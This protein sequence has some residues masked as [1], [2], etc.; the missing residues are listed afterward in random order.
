MKK[1]IY[2]VTLFILFMFSS[3][4]YSKTIIFETNFNSDAAWNITQPNA[5]GPNEIRNIPTAYTYGATD[6]PSTRTSV[7]VIPRWIGWYDYRTFMTTNTYNTVTLGTSNARGGSGNA[8]THYSEVPAVDSSGDASSGTLYLFLG[9][10]LTSKGYTDIW[11]TVWRKF[12]TNYYE[13][14]NTQ[15]WL[16]VSHYNH[17]LYLS[18]NARHLTDWSGVTTGGVEQHTPKFIHGTQ[19]SDDVDSGGLPMRWHYAWVRQFPYANRT[20]WVPVV[21]DLDAG[22]WKAGVAGEADVYATLDSGT[23]NGG[24][25]TSG[26]Y[27]DGDYHCHE[28]HLKLNSA[29][30]VAD[31]VLEYYIDGVAQ[32]S[33]NNMQWVKSGTPSDLGWN[34]IGFGGNNSYYRPAGELET[35]Y[36]YDDIVVSDYRVTS[37][38]RVGYPYDN[39]TYIKD[40]PAWG[41]TPTYQV[42]ATP[43]PLPSRGVAYRDGKFDTVLYRLTDYSD[44][45]SATILRYT[46]WSPENCDE[47]RALVVGGGSSGGYSFVVVDVNKNSPT[48]AKPL[49]TFALAYSYLGAEILCEPRWHPTDPNKFYWLYG[50][51]LY[52]VDITDAAPDSAKTLV[53]DF[54]SDFP[55]MVSIGTADEGDSS[56]NGR[57]WTWLVYDS[58]TYQYVFVYDSVSNTIISQIDRAEL[59]SRHGSINNV[60]SSDDGSYVYIGGSC[61]PYSSCEDYP[62]HSAA[63]YNL[64][65]MGSDFSKTGVTYLNIWA[66]HQ[67]TAKDSVGNNVAAGFDIGGDGYGY[68][69]V[70]VSATRLMYRPWPIENGTQDVSYGYFSAPFSS[71]VNGWSL[72]SHYPCSSANRTKS[73]RWSACLVGMLNLKSIGYNN[74][75]HTPTPLFYH[76]FHTYSGAYG[77]SGVG[78]VTANRSGSRVYFFTSWNATGDTA[79]GSARNVWMAELPE[80]WWQSSQ[81]GGTTPPSATGCTMSGTSFR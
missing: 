19:R 80:N 77:D 20:D 28:Y 50:M 79:G 59:V 32:F 26:N 13:G 2:L 62:S 69:G 24:W 7:G 5:G 15:K 3:L 61:D 73:N 43:P 72:V 65:T 64:S 41:T 34:S 68:V 67:D 42:D 55:G 63:F 45:S 66:T 53:R 52:L 23:R 29:S 70:G 14:N 57:Y 56:A 35:W 16:S 4:G 51:K 71:S 40:V 44:Y 18:D 9:D 22:D 38:Y 60:M 78:E 33:F 81:L 76:L 46:H 10:A 31:G 58:S 47:T 75:T 54:S 74:T 8:I 1:M 39:Y 6:F 21:G 17:S 37:S 48:F 49:K 11:I 36:A 30:N 12:D 27:G 25:K